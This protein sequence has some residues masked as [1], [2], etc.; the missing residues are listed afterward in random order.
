MTPGFPK[1]KS[2]VEGKGKQKVIAI[3]KV[4]KMKVPG[5]EI[6]ESSGIKITTRVF[7]WSLLVQDDSAPKKVVEERQAKR[8]PKEK[9]E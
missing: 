7:N 8:Y 2:T 1:K 4:S 6:G 3:P 5:K 9:L